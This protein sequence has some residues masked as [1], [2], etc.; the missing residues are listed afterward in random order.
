V[1]FGKPLIARQVVAHRLVE[2]H[3]R[4]A[5]ARTYTRHLPMRFAAGEQPFA[6]SCLAK[7]AATDACDFVAD[8]AILLHGGMGFMRESEVERHYRDARVLGISGGAREA[9]TDWAAKLLGYTQ[10]PRL[11]RRE[12]STANSVES[13]VQLCFSTWPLWPARSHH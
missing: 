9:L 11:T 3:Q 7:N 5:L 13:P 12:S 1:T 10:E 4:I 8:Q 6:E 2:M